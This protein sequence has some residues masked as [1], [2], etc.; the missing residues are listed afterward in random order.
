MC[1]DERCTDS[2]GLPPASSLSSARTRRLRRSLW[3]N[4]RSMVR[5]SLLLAFLA[6][7]VFALVAHAFA[8]VGLRRTRRTQLGG[9]LPHLLLVDARHG[10]QLLLGARH[11][12][13]ETGRHLV[14]HIVAVADLQLDVL[15]LHGGAETDAVDLQRLAVALGDALDQVD[16]LGARHAPHGTRLLAV[17]DR[18]HLDARRRLGDFDQLGAREGQLALRSLHR[19]FLTGDSGGHARR[20]LNRFLAYPRHARSTAFRPGSLA[21]TSRASGRA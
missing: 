1:L 16:D 6:E 18:A 5:P 19:H 4:L 9:E 21:M 12:Y 11:L 8:L 2:L 15:A 14:D 3:F 13:V 17:V 20:S 10:D 7:D